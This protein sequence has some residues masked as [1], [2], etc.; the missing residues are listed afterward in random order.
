M[1]AQILKAKYQGKLKIA[2]K[3]LICAV[4]EDDTRVISRNAV[5]KAFG[6]T[7]RGRKQDEIRVLNMP[8]FIDANNLQPFISEDLQGVLIPI[9][10]YNKNGTITTGY[11]AEILPLLC[12]VYLAARAADALTKHQQP[13]AIVSEILVRSLSKVGIIA[14]VDEATGYQEERT[15]DELQRFLSMYLSDEKLAWAKMFPD[16]YYKYLFRLWGWSYNPM[17][18]KRP[19]LVGK[20]TNQLVIDDD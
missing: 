5:F 12:D 6:R 18:V 20:L 1:G 4:L 15:Q 14:L 3:D 13:L 17:N 7:K 16:E 9:E 10:Y 8:S 19:K 2:D 11:K